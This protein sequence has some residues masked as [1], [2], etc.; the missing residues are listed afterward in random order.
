MLVLEDR[1]KEESI[2][3][4]LVQVVLAV[5]AV[6]EDLAIPAVLI[7]L[8]LVVPAVLALLMHL[9]GLVARHLLVV[10]DIR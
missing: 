2:L 7:Q 1:A 3:D 10:L 6:L 4:T 8:L 5:Q 9:V